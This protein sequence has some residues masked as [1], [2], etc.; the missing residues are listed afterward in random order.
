[1]LVFVLCFFDR[2]V[3]A[4][5]EPSPA[6]TAVQ[7]NADIPKEY[8]I[9]EKSLSPN[10]RFAILYPIRGDDRGELP[11]NLLVCLT[12]YSV[13][14]QIGTQACPC[15]AERDEPLTTRNGTPMVATWIAAR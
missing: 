5:E 9:G 14:T 2:L 11:P 13:L 1:M 4:A 10:G 3:L 8:E 6:E 7:L 12:P 15:Q